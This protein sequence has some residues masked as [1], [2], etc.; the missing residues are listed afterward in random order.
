MKPSSMMR[1]GNALWLVGLV[2]LLL[3]L[4]IQ[5][6]GWTRLDWPLV[7]AQVQ[8][9]QVVKHNQAN[10]QS[11]STRQWLVQYAYKYVWDGREYINRELIPHSQKNTDMAGL[12]SQE[13]EYWLL[14]QGPAVWEPIQIWVNPKHPAQSLLYQAPTAPSWFMAAGA[15]L[16][17]MWLVLRLR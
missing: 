2:L 5:F 1:W 10:E 3:G 16:C 14:R 8:D 6:G 4:V 15:L 12:T 7:A 9:V 17:V 13:Y 11:I